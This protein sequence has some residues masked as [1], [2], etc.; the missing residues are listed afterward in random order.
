MWIP[1]LCHRSKWM[2]AHGKCSINVIHYNCSGAILICRLF[3]C[4]TLTGLY[5][6]WNTVCPTTTYVRYTQPHSAHLSA[7]LLL[8]L[9]VGFRILLWFCF[10]G[11]L[12]GKESACSAGDTGSISGLGSPLGEE[13]GYALQHS[14]LEN[15]MD[16]GAWQ[17]TV[18]GVTKSWIWLRDWITTT[19]V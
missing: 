11:G 5:Q 12:D 17:A 13:N 19:K 14:C 6:M 4:I 18:H 2:K 1:T 8:T 3:Q 10:P 9:G 7:K 16:R 15:P